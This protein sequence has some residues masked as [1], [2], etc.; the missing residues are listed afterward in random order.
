MSN[1]YRITSKAGADFGVYQGATA[2]EAFAA[3]VAESGDG[4]DTDGNSTAGT[5]ADWI[6]EEV[7]TVGDWTG[8]VDAARNL[9]DDDLAEAIH[10]TVDAEQEFVDAYMVAHRAKYGSDYTVN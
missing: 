1:S 9:M 5:M 7:V 2:E 10:G 8:P 4:V 3:M 6:I